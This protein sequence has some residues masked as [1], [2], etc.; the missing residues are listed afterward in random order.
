M[1]FIISFF[2]LLSMSSVVFS[3]RNNPNSVFFITR[4][5]KGPISN[6]IEHLPEII[7][8]D[9]M[10]ESG[11]GYLVEAKISDIEGLI[12]KVKSSICRAMKRG[13]FKIW[14]KVDSA[15]KIVGIGPSSESNIEVLVRCN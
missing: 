5:K 1:R 10:E 14:L 4:S 6:S 8:E 9:E 3:K 13:E 15:S 11:G 12:K 2:I 7:E